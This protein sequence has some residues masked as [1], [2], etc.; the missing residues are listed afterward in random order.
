LPILAALVRVERTTVRATLGVAKLRVLGRTLML[1]GLLNLW[2]VTSPSEPSTA[3]TIEGASGS[4]LLDPTKSTR[5]TTLSN[6][7]VLSS[8]NPAHV[9][10][11][12]AV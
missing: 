1:L 4:G 3:S 12:A 5:R 6:P 9:F 2:A 10:P 8:A 7:N 11:R